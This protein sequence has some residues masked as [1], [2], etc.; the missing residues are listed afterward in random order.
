MTNRRF[1]ERRTTDYIVIHT[2]A[3]TPDMDI[4]LAEIDRWH[5][6]RGFLAVGYHYIIRRDGTLED[7]R[8]EDTV[9]AHV[10]GFNDKSIGI[11][12][13]GGLN[14]DSQP[15]DNYTELQWERLEKVVSFLE[16]QYPEARVMGHREMPGV[17]KACPCFNVQLWLIDRTQQKVEPSATITQ[18]PEE[19]DHADVI[20]VDRTNEEITPIY[21]EVRKKRRPWWRP[22]WLFGSS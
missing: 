22:S 2:S 7:G 16:Q 21:V 14:D 8:P 18:E 13:V 17:K 4:G 9:G 10:R 11:C 3:T 5:R 15:D 6:E 19:D 12:M 1:K 20:Y